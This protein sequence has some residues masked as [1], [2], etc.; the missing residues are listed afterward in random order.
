MTPVPPEQ[1]A[2]VLRR[3][4]FGDAFRL[5][6]R[7]VAC[8]PGRQIEVEHTMPPDDPVALAHFRSGPSIYPGV[9]LIEVANQAAIALGLISGLVAERTQL[10]LIETH[11]S[12]RHPAMPGKPLRVVVTIDS[13]NRVGAGYSGRGY[14]DERLV[15]SVQCTTV[16]RED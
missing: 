1:S 6:D 8:A 10:F 12:F 9:L 13:V 5:V 3:L 7:I 4:P 15:F 2:E 11:A 14:Q 16:K